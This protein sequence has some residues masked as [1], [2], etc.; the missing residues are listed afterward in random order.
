M[1]FAA[2]VELLTA[3]VSVNGLA[4]PPLTPL[5]RMRTTYSVAGASSS[6]LFVLTPVSSNSCPIST[7]MPSPGASE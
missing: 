2:S 1:Q 4:S 3:I 5:A 6:E 7:S